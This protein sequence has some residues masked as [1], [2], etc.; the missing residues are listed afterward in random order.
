MLSKKEN[1]ETDSDYSIIFSELNY[2]F[3]THQLYA[4]F[5][6]MIKKQSFSDEKYL[7]NEIR[8]SKT[9]TIIMI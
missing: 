9:T 2:Y 1:N 8:M 7:E 3:Y 5:I 4:A 6:M